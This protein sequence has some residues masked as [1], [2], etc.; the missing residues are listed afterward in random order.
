MNKNVIKNTFI[1]ALILFLSGC[2]NTILPPLKTFNLQASKDCCKKSLNKQKLT[3]K[4]L[5]PTTNK[6]LNTT[7]IYY[8]SDK[9]RLQTYKLSRWSDYPTKMILDVLTSKLDELNLYEN[10]TTSKIYA[11]SD[12]TLQSELFEF[13]QV[14]TKSEAFVKLKIKFYIIKTNNDKKI[15]SKIFEYKTKCD[16]VDAYGAIK[17]LN[18]S[19]DLLINNLS[20][21]IYN[22]TK[23]Q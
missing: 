6:Y 5:E 20:L 18:N 9:Y 3:I 19:I 17:A 23:E 15:I 10:I 8:S 11:A 2:S 22:N 13:K 4:I 7:S 16:T 21:W 14:I 12:Y 1:V